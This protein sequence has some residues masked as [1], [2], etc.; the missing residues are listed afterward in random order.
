MAGFTL[1]KKWQGASVWALYA[2]GM[3]PAVFTFYLGATGSLGADPVKTFERTLGLWALRFLIATLAVSPLR[4][5]TGINLLRYRRAL[6]LLTF[7]YALMHF[8]AY[9]LLDQ[10]LDLQAVIADIVKRPYI[11]IGMACL[12]LLVPLAVTS[13]GYSIRKLGRKWNR[14][15]KLVY[16]IAAGAALHFAMLVKVISLEPFVYISIVAL[17]LAYRIVRPWLSHRR[18]KD[19]RVLAARQQA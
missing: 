18:K 9:M 4:D 3:M 12:L 2:I 16:L 7:Y 11:T 10:R 1:P 6:G 13:N 17:L 5:L 19:G 14:L 8:G 15:H